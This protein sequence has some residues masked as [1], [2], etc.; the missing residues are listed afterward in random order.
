MLTDGID[1]HSSRGRYSIAMLAPPWAPITS[2]SRDVEL[3]I[4][5]LCTGLV[6][7]GHRVTLFAA[8]GTKC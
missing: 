2:K 1:R 5:L 8:P 7:R 6:Q 4:G 3:A